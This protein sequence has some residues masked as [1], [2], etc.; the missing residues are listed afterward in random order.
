[1]PL[2]GDF[3]VAIIARS[4]SLSAVCIALTQSPCTRLKRKGRGKRKGKGPIACV[5]ASSQLSSR[6]GACNQLHAT[7]SCDSNSSKRTKGQLN[8]AHRSFWAPIVA[9][10]ERERE[11]GECDANLVNKLQR[12][13]IN[14]A[15]SGLSQSKVTPNA[16][17]AS[18]ELA[19]SLAIECCIVSV[20]AVIYLYF[21][22]KSEPSVVRTHTHTQTH[23]RRRQFE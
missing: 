3:I 2:L 13:A 17:A 12:P 8:A 20:A 18:A 4:L 1:M 15:A 19:G 21:W 23:N 11:P 7:G 5:Q 6:V 9:R 14:S 16:A 10:N 22:P